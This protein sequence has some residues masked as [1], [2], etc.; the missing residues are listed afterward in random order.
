MGNL[1]RCEARVE[2]E[3]ETW[4]FG[5]IFFL[6]IPNHM[7]PCA[8][9]NSKMPKIRTTLKYIVYISTILLR[10]IPHIVSRFPPLSIIPISLLTPGIHR[11]QI[12]PLLIYIYAWNQS[13]ISRRSPLICRA[14]HRH[15]TLCKAFF[16]L[17]FLI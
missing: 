17:Y 10:L 8:R 6:F 15:Q 2:I 9:K 14:M 1:H 5:D 11:T 3:I 4:N 7:S 12:T 13:T 16:S